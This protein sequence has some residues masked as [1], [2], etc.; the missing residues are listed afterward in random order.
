MR[1]SIQIRTQINKNK[2]VDYCLKLGH[3]VQNNLSNPMPQS[4]VI[5]LHSVNQP[6]PVQPVLN[7]SDPSNPAPHQAQ[8]YAG[9]HIVLYI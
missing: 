5:E 4:E 9:K 2:N 1:T 8:P 6:P 3:P 7:Q